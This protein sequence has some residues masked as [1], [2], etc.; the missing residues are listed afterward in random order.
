MSIDTFLRKKGHLLILSATIMSTKTQLKAD[1][2]IFCTVFIQD[3]VLKTD[4]ENRNI[5]YHF[6]RYYSLSSRKTVKSCNHSS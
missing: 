5:I 6:E 1:D 4:T 2:N 3:N